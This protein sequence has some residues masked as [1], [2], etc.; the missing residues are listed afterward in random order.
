MAIKQYDFTGTVLKGRN[1]K[2]LLQ[3]EEG[4]E[5]LLSAVLVRALD[6]VDLRKQNPQTGAPMG[7]ELPG[8][9]RKRIALADKIESAEGVLQLESAEADL[10]DRVVT[11]FFA[12]KI[13][14][15]ILR[16]FDEAK[17]KAAETEAKTAAKVERASKKASKKAPKRGKGKGKG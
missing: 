12:P 7:H 9:M 1:G 6:E 10:L 11:A 17:E 8:D 15:R 3:D 2:G 4:E 16:A 5:M 14:T 13:S